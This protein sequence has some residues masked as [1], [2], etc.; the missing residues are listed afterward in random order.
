[1]PQQLNVQGPKLSSPAFE[2]RKALPE[3]HT[4]DRDDVARR[5]DESARGRGRSNRGPE[6]VREP[7]LNR[8]A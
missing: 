5:C 8:L 2:D 6:L 3:R 1:M 7:G 4:R